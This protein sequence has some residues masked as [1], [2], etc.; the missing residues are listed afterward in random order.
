MADGFLKRLAMVISFN[1]KVHP[2]NIS[3]FCYQRLFQQ[4]PLDAQVPQAGNEKVELAILWFLDR[5]HKRVWGSSLST[6]Q[7]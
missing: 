7:R 1:L 2:E 4:V 5:F 3:F 6:P